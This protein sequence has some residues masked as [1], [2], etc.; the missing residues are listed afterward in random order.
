MQAVYRPVS[1]P[2]FTPEA[3][4][5]RRITVELKPGCP[6]DGVAYIRFMNP[7]TGRVLPERGLYTLTRT[8]PALNVP[9]TFGSGVLP[10]WEVWW[11]KPLTAQEWRVPLIR[12]GRTP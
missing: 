1:W 8:Q 6:P 11:V 7:I 9:R 10:T 4:R 5:L 12:A 2:W 3:E